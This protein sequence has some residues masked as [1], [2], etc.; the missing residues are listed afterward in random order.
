[1]DWYRHE[2]SGELSDQIV[3]HK[4][5]SYLPFFPNSDG[6]RN[7]K[8]IDTDIGNGNHI[9]E[10]FIENTQNQGDSD[11]LNLSPA[12]T[13]TV[14]DIVLV[15]GYAASLGLFLDNFEKLSAI[16]GVR[17]HAIDMLGFGFSS[18]PSYPS[19]GVS[20]KEDIY[21]NED[22]FIDSIEEWRKRRGIS[23][24]ILIGHSFGGYLS[25]AYARKYNQKLYSSEDGG[26]AYRMIEKL[27]LLSPVGVERNANSLLKNESTPAAQASAVDKSR[28]N[29]EL[30]EVEISRE[31]SANQEDIVNPRQASAGTVDGS[32]ESDGS[33]GSPGNGVTDESSRSDGSGKPDVETKNVESEGKLSGNRRNKTIKF[34]WNKHVSPF[35]I[36]RGL[37]LIRSKL[38]SGWTTHRFSHIYYTDPEKFQSIHNYFY[39]VFKAPGSGEYAITRVLAYGALARLPLLDRCPEEFVKMDLPTLWMYGDKDWMNRDAG[40]E[41]TKEINDLAK[42]QGKPAL[43]TFKTLHNAGHHLY[44]DN[45]DQFAEAFYDFM[46]I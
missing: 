38:I 15:H 33:Y 23:H 29:T 13:D 6:K 35:S 8:I 30:P 45:P 39:R 26:A 10:F 37:G 25:C 44:L 42:A 32:A 31:I 12:T 20:S 22:W 41:I 36:V 9:H 1:M 4:L 27:V 2:V 17:I 11:L 16:P 40:K 34:L 43:A 18:R 21:A 46:K 19:Y 5:L 14:K 24:F 7:A 3:E 28:E